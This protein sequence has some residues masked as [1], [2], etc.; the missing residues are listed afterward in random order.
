MIFPVWFGLKR[1]QHSGTARHV[2]TAEHYVPEYDAPLTEHENA[3]SDTD[4]TSNFLL[5]PLESSPLEEVI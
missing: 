4:L 5:R 1:E 3:H 2:N